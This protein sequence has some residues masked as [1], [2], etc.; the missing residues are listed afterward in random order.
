MSNKET[1]HF[2]IG[3]SGTYWDKK[4]HYTVAIDDQVF[5]DQVIKGHSKEVEYVEFDV[6]IAEG[7]HEL[8]IRLENK[9]DRDVEQDGHG[10]ILNDMLLNIESIEVDEI[11]FGNLIWSASEFHADHERIIKGEDLSVLKEC[12][13]LGWNGTY[14]IKFES[15]FYLWLLTEL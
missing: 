11:N 6:D 4:P 15:P 3:V 2:K 9:S 8:K 10:N 1:L 5:A 13:N 12:V 14:V 7:L